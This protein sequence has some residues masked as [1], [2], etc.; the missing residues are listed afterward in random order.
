VGLLNARAGC[1]LAIGEIKQ[2]LGMEIYQPEREQEVLR[3]VR[4]VNS[5]P[6]DDDAIGRLFER[7]IDEAR[8]L[9]RIAKG[10]GGG[11]AD[12]ASTTDEASE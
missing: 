5:G 1:A 12:T 7:I 6:L 10:T 8:R 9:E 3:H 2:A 4:S 11:P